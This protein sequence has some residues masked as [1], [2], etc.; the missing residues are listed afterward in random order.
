MSATTNITFRS[1]ITAQTHKL[2]QNYL[3]IWVNDDINLTNEDCENILIQ[4]HAVVK[5]VDH[6]STT[7]ECIE[8]LNKMDD[9][10][11]FVI[12]SGAA[13]QHLVFDIHNMAQVHTI[14]IFCDNK[15]LHEGWVNEWPKIEG[16]FTDI[17]SI[18]ESLK[19]VTH[20]CDHDAIS[21]SFVPNRETVITKSDQN[22]LDEL[23]PSFMYSTLF[24]EIA[25]EIDEDDNKLISDLVAYCLKKKKDIPEQELKDF[26]AEYHQKSPIWWY[27][28]EN[29]LYPMLNYA[30]RTLDMETMTKMVFFIRSL[31]LQLQELHKKQLDTYNEQFVV[32]RGQGLSQKDFQQLT[33]TKGGLLSFNNFLSTSTKQKVAMA[34]I[35]TSLKKCTENVG[36]LF[37]ITIDPKK[38]STSTST[39][40]ALID[41]YS[42]MG[43]REKEILFS[44]HT[45]FRVDDVKQTLTNTRRWEVQLTLTD[46]HDQQLTGLKNCMK[47]ELRGSTGWHRLGH[48]MIKVAHFNQAEELY[49]QLL[50]NAS[51]DD[52]QAHI[53]HQLGILK[54]YQG[55]YNEA[56][57]FYERSLAIRQRTLTEDDPSLALTYNDLALVY[58]SMGEYSKALEFHEKSQQI[59]EKALPPNHPDLAESYNNIGQVYSNMGENSKALEFYQKSHEIKEKA[60]PPNHP[61][62]ATSYNN[63][64]SVY[65]NIGEYSKALE[66]YEKSHQIREKALPPNHPSLATSYNNIGQVYNNMGEYSKALELYEKDLEITKKALPPNHPNLATSYSNIGQVYN[67]MGEYSKA[68]EL[69]E[70]DHEITIYEKALPPNHPSLATSYNNIGRVYK[71]MGEYS[72]ALEFYEKSHQIFEKALPPNHPSLATSYNSTGLVYNNMGEYSKALEFYE[73][74]HQIYEKALPPNHPSL[75]TSYNNIGQVYNNMG[76]Y[77]KALEFYEKSHQIREKSLPPNHPSLATSYNNIGAVYYHMGEYSKALEF[78][79]KSHQ[80]AEKSLPPNHPSLATSYSNIG[81]VYY[82]MG[83]YSKAA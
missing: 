63:I 75:A 54:Y 34:F 73:K 6:C 74:S 9:E 40:F 64:G 58:N 30:L 65:N 42:A 23:P 68:L 3:L 13:G 69:Y 44:I 33:D 37:I 11:A 36:I 61:S 20:E 46:D 28:C 18:C 41:H 32:Y 72:K 19:K 70:K 7:A 17:K 71:N 57:K 38:I 66:F 79:E 22:K 12:S 5:K 77:S 76:E 35:N 81:Q 10:K 2:V 47:Q 60:L 80:I 51:S 8:L 56:V 48:L 39:S 62:L 31:H 67:N 4:L 26:Q 24:K 16:V 78:Y 1:N 21:M 25:S 45:V 55:E 82:N 52:D 14:Y 59:R 43:T 27:S 15:E 83:E 49:N 53:Y 29:F 50:E